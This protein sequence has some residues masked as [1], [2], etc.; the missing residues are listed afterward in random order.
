MRDG[1]SSVFPVYL[2]FSG[3]KDV[4]ILGLS[5]IDPHVVAMGFLSLARSPLTSLFTE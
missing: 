2:F 4:D 5:T 3:H 1:E